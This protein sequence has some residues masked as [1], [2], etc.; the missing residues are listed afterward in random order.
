MFNSHL[1]DKDFKAFFA[2]TLTPI[3]YISFLWSPAAKSEEHNLGYKVWLDLVDLPPYLWALD[4]LA[5]LT[6]SFG[7]ILAHSSLN[8]VASFEWLQLSIATDALS[9]ISRAI[10]LFLNGRMSHIPL[11]VTGWIRETTA[12]EAL[13]D[14][15]PSDDIYATMAATLHG[16]M[17]LSIARRSPAPSTSKSSG[18]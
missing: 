12:F 15:T 11:V 2:K 8:K 7:L 3:G 13:K 5:V 18:P 16:R 1:T 4:E 17:E 6:S 10:C 14:Y 9:K